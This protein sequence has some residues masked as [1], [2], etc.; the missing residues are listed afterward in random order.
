MMIIDLSLPRLFIKDKIDEVIF[1]ARMKGFK[2]SK[3]QIASVITAAVVLGCN[4][5]ALA[6]QSTIKID[7][8]MKQNTYAIIFSILE[9]FKSCTYE[10]I[11]NMGL[12]FK[13]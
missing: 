8:D 1:E 7:E 13:R 9:I 10:D 6:C 11:K 12:Y 4:N 2:L 3:P 5:D